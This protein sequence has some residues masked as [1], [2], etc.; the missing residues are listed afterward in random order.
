MGSRDDAVRVSRL[1]E[2]FTPGLLAYFLRRVDTP[3]DAADLLSD[4]LLVLWRKARDV[5]HEDSEARMWMYGVA[6]QVLLTHKRAH[7]RRSALH[8][9]LRSELA[10]QPTPDTADREAAELHAALAQLDP[11]DREILRLVHWDGFS[12]A[13]A[14]R[15]LHLPEGTVRSR[16]LRARRRLRA[17]LAPPASH[18]ER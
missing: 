15:L 9:R 7:S 5:P 11:T 2:Q 4:T 1:V 13:D 12:Q 17:T 3:A 8:D 18:L 6:R 10:A 16:H 14:A